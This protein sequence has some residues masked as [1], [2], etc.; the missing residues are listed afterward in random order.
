M[1]FKVD[2]QRIKIAWDTTRPQ[3]QCFTQIC[4]VAPLDQRCLSNEIIFKRKAGM[5]CHERESKGEGS[6][7]SQL[8]PFSWLELTELI[9]KC[10]YF[11]CSFDLDIRKGTNDLRWCQ[12]EVLEIIGGAQDTTVKVK[13]DTQ[14][15]VHIY[16]EA[17]LSNQRLLP[18]R[19]RKAR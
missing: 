10:M 12:G 5:A 6:M 17:T 16:E 19:W 11:L 7:C 1:A 9:S 13:W 14:L 8:Q 4:N 2:R 15:D 18:C 3:H